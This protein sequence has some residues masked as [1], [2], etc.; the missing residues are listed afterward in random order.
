VA[1]PNLSL[2]RI[3][4]WNVAV[5]QALG[6]NQALTMTYLGSAGRDLLRNYDL[7]APDPNFGSL[8]SVTTNQ[9]ASNYQ[10]LQVQFQRQ[11]SH[12]LQVLASYSY[13]HSI[14]NASDSYSAYSPVA[15]GSPNIDRGNS[16]F[17]VRHSGSGA[18]IY[19]LPA[20]PHAKQSA[21]PPLRA[22]VC[23]GFG[24]RADSFSG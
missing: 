10:A 8:V 4:Q 18:L 20:P 5:E 16:A 9:G 7:D 22:M 1:E 6:R 17:D 21:A 15:L 11:A 23:R 19:E 3:Y 24:Y 13:S 12:G 14:D 2:P